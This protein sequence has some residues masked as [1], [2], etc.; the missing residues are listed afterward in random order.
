LS[1]AVAVARPDA[2][3]V[4]P[5]QTDTSGPAAGS[6]VPVA[7][8]LL[9]STVTPAGGNR[10]SAIRAS[11]FSPGS[12]DARRIRLVIAARCRHQAC[13]KRHQHRLPERPMLLHCR[14]PK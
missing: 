1:D 8:A 9:P 11:A 10:L 2:G 5:G 6:V 12:F 14:P 13:A 4:F 7:V 3:I